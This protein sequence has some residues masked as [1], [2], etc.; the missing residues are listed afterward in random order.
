M[1]HTMM[2][3]KQRWEAFADILSDDLVNI[4]VGQ[5]DGLALLRAE[6]LKFMWHNSQQLKGLK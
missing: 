1:D 6:S 3:H 2:T 5:S 4:H